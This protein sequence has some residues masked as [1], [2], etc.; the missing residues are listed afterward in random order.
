MQ[1]QRIQ[2]VL[3]KLLDGVDIQELLEELHLIELLE[4]G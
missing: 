4:E 2:Q 1:K 3:D